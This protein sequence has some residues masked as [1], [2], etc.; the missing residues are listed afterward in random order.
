M[1]KNHTS[2]LVSVIIPSYNHAQY[3]LTCLNSIIADDYPNKE[4]IVLDDGSTDKSVDTI[5]QWYET[6]KDTIKYPFKLVYRENRGLTKTLNELV[7]SS[8]GEYVCPIASDDYLLPGSI[9][10][11]VV[12]LEAN[13]T[14]KAVFGDYVVVDGNGERLFD[15][16]IERK[17]RK[18]FLHKD[19][20]IAS[21]MTFYWCLSGP[22]LIVK[23]EVYDS[24]RGYD[25]RLVVEDWDFYLQ[26][27]AK[28]WLGFINLPVG[29]Y[30]KHE[31]N[32]SNNPQVWSKL[33]DSLYL[34]L[35]NNFPHFKGL[36]KWN[37]YARKL[38]LQAKLLRKKNSMINYYIYVFLGR[39]LKQVTKWLYEI[40]IAF[41]FQ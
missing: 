38:I 1:E 6:Q 22:V 18:K 10:E 23:R 13:P 27:C 30:R 39:T 5:K 35:T 33:H 29:A 32:T 16:G 9:R 25:E 14:K 17:G 26:L 36:V 34:T 11:R 20:L 19:N 12:Y 4:I 37:L 7:A 24:I 8:N 15:S 3:I 41:S 21:E 40:K 2:P 28:G 31:K